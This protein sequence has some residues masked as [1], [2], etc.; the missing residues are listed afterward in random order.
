MQFGQHDV[1]EIAFTIQRS[2]DIESV[3]LVLHDAKR[4]MP[5]DQEVPGYFPFSFEADIN[6][7]TKKTII[8]ADGIGILQEMQSGGVGLYVG[9]I[10]HDEESE[11]RNLKAVE[12]SIKSGFRFYAGDTCFHFPVGGDA[13]KVLDILLSPAKQFSS[14][15]RFL[16]DSDR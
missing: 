2:I 13:R 5:K 6:A 14:R 15:V 10:R 8:G 7:G 11:L 3:Q 4:A 12:R 16:R 1:H 9:Q